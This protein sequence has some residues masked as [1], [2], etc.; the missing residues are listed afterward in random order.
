MDPNSLPEVAKK[1]FE[2][3]KVR[4]EDEAKKLRTGRA[5]PSMVEGVSAVCYGQAMPLIQL[6][7]ITTPE[8][9]LIQISPFDPSN[10]AAITA[11]IR[12]NQSLGLNP[13]DDGHVIRLQVPP[14]TT[15]RRSQIVKQLHEKLEE[16][17]IAMRGARHDAR[18]KLTQAEKDKQASKDDVARIEKQI[19]EHMARVKTEIESAAKAKEQ[20][21]MT[22]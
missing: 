19:D 15:E 5:H 6:A 17:M 10:L 1:E 22:L 20:E 3:A 16:C 11:A 9:Q 14:L 7:T 18:G 12:D 8:P 21:I 4:F 13:S 2:R